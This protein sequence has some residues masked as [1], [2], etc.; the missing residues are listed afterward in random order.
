ESRQNLKCLAAPRIN[1]DLEGPA[2]SSPALRHKPR[3]TQFSGSRKDA[4]PLRFRNGIVLLDGNA[5]SFAPWRLGVNNSSLLCIA[6]A[7]RKDAEPLRF[8]NGH[9]ASRIKHRLLFRCEGGD[10]RVEAH[11]ARSFSP[12]SAATTAN[13]PVAITDWRRLSAS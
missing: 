4:K 12:A 11:I 13:Q 2:A 8:R 5:S 3:S 9:P 7:S 6:E 10:D 1:T